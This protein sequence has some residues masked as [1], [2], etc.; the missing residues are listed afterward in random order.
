MVSPGFMENAVDLKDPQLL[1]MK[2]AAELKEV[3]RV[4]AFLFEPE[5]S[6]VT[7]QNIEVSVDLIFRKNFV[8][9]T[10]RMHSLINVD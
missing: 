8:S 3:A 4:V 9:H 10:H 2:R 1:P 6:Y 5:S 7:G